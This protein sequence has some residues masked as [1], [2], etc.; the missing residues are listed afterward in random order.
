MRL[1]KPAAHRASRSRVVMAALLAAALWAVGGPAHAA[2]PP[3][4]STFYITIGNALLCLDQ[5]DINYFYRYLGDALGPPY[6]HEDGAYWFKTKVM[7]WKVPVSE[8]ALSDGH[9]TMLFLEAVADVTPEKL[10]QAVAAEAGIHHVA[11]DAGAYPRRVSNT[12]S[13][14]IYFHKKAKIYC[15]KSEYLLPHTQ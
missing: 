6:K 12:G 9:G 15:G 4:P 5:L 7:L 10:E 14:I 3:L 8:I 11:A 1:K 13:D 2:P